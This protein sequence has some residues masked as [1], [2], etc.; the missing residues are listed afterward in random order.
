MYGPRG[1]ESVGPECRLCLHGEHVEKV[2]N[3]SKN[4]TPNGRVVLSGQPA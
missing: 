3:A 4:P 2:V 1:G